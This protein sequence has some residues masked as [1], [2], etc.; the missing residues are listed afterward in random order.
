MGTITD[1]DQSIEA[2]YEITRTCPEVLRDFRHPVIITT[3]SDRT[4]AISIYSPP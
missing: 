3:K 4:S 1:P 2:L